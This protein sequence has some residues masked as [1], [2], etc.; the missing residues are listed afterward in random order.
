MSRTLRPTIRSSMWS[1][2]PTPWRMPISAARSISSTSPGRSPASATRPAR[3]ELDGHDL[4]LVGRQLRPRDELEDVVVGRVREVLDPAPL[5]GAPPQ[6]VVDRVGRALRPAL[7]RDAVLARV[8]D[9]LVA[10]HRPRAH[11]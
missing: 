2:I 6:V 11:G 8:R 4:G 5:R 10:P 7:D 3:L 1:T 9:L